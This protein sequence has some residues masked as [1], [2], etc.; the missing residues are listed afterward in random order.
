M[1]KFAFLILTTIIAFNISA[2]VPIP[3]QNTVNTVTNSFTD[4][5][6]VEYE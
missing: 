6:E 4:L 1:K 5:S 2:N 3:S